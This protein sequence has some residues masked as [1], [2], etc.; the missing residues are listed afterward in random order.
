MKKN[1]CPHCGAWGQLSKFCNRCGNTIIYSTVEAGAED[2]I[3]KPIA[4]STQ[5]FD[6]PLIVFFDV[7]LT[8]IVLKI[9]GVS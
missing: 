6:V 8:F 1:S 4:K 5:N 7:I 3:N 2:F 9:L